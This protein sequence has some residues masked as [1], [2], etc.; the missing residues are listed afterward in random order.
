MPLNMPFNRIAVTTQ[1]IQPT[2]RSFLYPRSFQITRRTCPHIRYASVQFRTRPRTR[3]KRKVAQDLSTIPE[4]DFP[5]D[6]GLFPG[7]AVAS[8]L[9]NRKSYI[10]ATGTLIMPTRKPSLF[11]QPRRRARLEWYRITQRANDFRRSA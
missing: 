1:K 9:P 6:F 5:H 3:V 7:I 2:L 4:S 11:F 10:A 8:Y